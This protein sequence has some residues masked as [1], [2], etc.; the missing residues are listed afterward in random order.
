MSEVKGILLEQATEDDAELLA[1]I[2]KLAFDTDVEVG[3]PDTGGPPGYDSPEFQIRA[4]GWADYYTILLDETLIGGLIIGS[5]NEDHLVMERIFLDPK[6]HRKGIGT[7]VMGLLNEL[8]PSTKLWTLGTPEWNV[9]TK[10]FYEKL[11]YVQVGWELGDP[12]SRGRWFEKVM[13]PEDPYTLTPIAE[14]RDGMKNLDV[15]G[16]V[17]EKGHA[18]M[19]RSR[20][21][22]GRTL[23]VANAA[24]KDDSGRVVLV[25]WNEQI[26]QVKVGDKVRVENGYVSSYRGVTQLNSGMAGRIIILI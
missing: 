23:S 24:I 21:R 1:Y 2:S 12:K 9:R 22:Y 19:V 10:N 17:V 26:K 4:M 15:N 14:L 7:Q 11:G 6:H 20:R 13:T 16:T 25:L 5:V 8:Y 18:R 3:A